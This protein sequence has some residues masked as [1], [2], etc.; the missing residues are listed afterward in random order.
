[1]VSRLTL[2]RPTPLV[3][4][5]NTPLKRAGGVA[6]RPPQTAQRREVS[7]SLP[8]PTADGAAVIKLTPQALKDVTAEAEGERL[9]RLADQ[10]TRGKLLLDL[11]EVPYLTSMW[12]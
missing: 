2:L 4:P 1:M 12:L 8:G 7:M 10:Q 3:L 9:L 6:A 11:G 5:T